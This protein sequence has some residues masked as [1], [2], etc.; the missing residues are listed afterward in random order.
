MSE[1]YEPYLDLSS[2]EHNNT[3]GVILYL[4]DPIDGKILQS[5]VEELRVRFSYFYV[6]AACQNGELTTVPNPLPMTVRNT[7]DPINF[8]SIDSNYHLAAWK[9]DDSRLAFEIPHSLTDGAGVLPYIKSTMYLYLSKATGQSFDPTGF[10]LPGDVIPDSEIGDPFRDIDFDSLEYPLYIKEPIPDFFRLVNETD[11]N[12]RVFFIKLPESQVMDYCGDN[13]ASPNVLFSVML[14]KAARRYDPA[15]EKTVTVSVA[16]NHKAILGNRDNYRMFAG[17]AILD[18]P[19]SWS[20]DDI[21]K[22]C[23]IGRGQLML[24]A[25]PENSIWSIKQRKRKLQSISFDVPQ[26]SICVSYASNRSF[27]PLDPYIAEMYIVTSLSKITDILCEVTCI[28]QSF[29]LAFLQPFSSEKY[30]ECFL[31]ELHLAGIHYE[32]LRR[33]PLQM[34]GIDRMEAF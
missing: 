26:A 13:D 8:N 6:K 12:K 29:F 25:D 2:P 18:F 24:Q 22:T 17:Q 1:Y 21:R 4:H 34:C 11:S 28:N 31:E 23:T 33:E 20:L 30:L 9:Y 27:G 19:K 32:L 3:M 16:I 15:C 10:R 14:A 7:W 5:A